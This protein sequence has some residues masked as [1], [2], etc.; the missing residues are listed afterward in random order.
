MSK[1]LRQPRCVDEFASKSPQAL[2]TKLKRMRPE[3]WRLMYA[4]RLGLECPAAVRTSPSCVGTHKQVGL[5]IRIGKHG[6]AL[7]WDPGLCQGS[8]S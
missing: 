1:P 5:P 3:Q 2:P 6:R 8:A 7:P 4:R